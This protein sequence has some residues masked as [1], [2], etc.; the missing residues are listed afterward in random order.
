[1]KSTIITSCISAMAMSADLWNDCD[2]VT[3]P[4]IQI[5]KSQNERNLLVVL[6]HSCS[7]PAVGPATGGQ[8]QNLGLF[9]LSVISS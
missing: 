9:S 8:P 3:T 7:L 5:S 4:D 1:M 2:S 6:H